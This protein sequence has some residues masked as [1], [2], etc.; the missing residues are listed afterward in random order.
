VPADPPRQ[1]LSF[2]AGAE[3]RHSR[4]AI[5][6]VPCQLKD[7]FVANFLY[8]MK[9]KGLYA[10]RH[11]MTQNTRATIV[12]SVVGLLGLSYLFRG[13]EADAKPR[14]SFGAASRQIPL[15][16]P[17][18][19]IKFPAPS[20]VPA[21]PKLVPSLPP[22]PSVP[23]EDDT[24]NHCLADLKIIGAEFSP[25]PSDRLDGRC[26]VITPIDLISLETPA[27]RITFPGKPTFNCTFA[28]Q[29]AKWLSNVAAP[30]VK[31]LAG[32]DLATLETGPGY[33]CRTR[34]GDA[35][36]DAKLSEH[37][38]GNAVDIT[39]LGLANKRQIGI[40]AVAD[41]SNPDHRLL[42]ALRLTACGYFTTVL[43]P[44][45][46]A[47]HATHYHLDLGVHGKSSNYRICE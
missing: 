15:P 3:V 38:T 12:F 36:Q 20:D 22:A 37:A 19:N 45:A 47:A 43:G 2:F 41:K 5:V 24:S 1:A 35:F 8:G 28:L 17:R 44:G 23:S 10:S 30:I 40:A 7:G 11:A 9:Y 21:V 46:N 34:N 6:C 39:S 33:V 29:F 26:P 25:T 4:S 27:G 18:P 42:M 32:S 13:V 16:V 31:I 14:L